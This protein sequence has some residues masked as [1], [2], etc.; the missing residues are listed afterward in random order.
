MQEQK[1][2][3]DPVKGIPPVRDY[4]SV[5][6][7]IRVCLDAL[8]Q[9]EKEAG[10]SELLASLRNYFD[11]AFV[12]LT[13][14]KEGQLT[15]VKE[16]HRDADEKVAQMVLKELTGPAAIPFLQKMDGFGDVIISDTET[17]REYRPDICDG[18]QK[19]QAESVISVPLRNKGQQVGMLSVVNPCVHREEAGLLTVLESPII[20][21]MELCSLKEKEQFIESHDTLTGLW[22]RDS[23]SEFCRSGEEMTYQSLGI[24]TTDVIHLSEINKKLGYVSGNRKLKE[25]AAFLKKMFPA[26]KIYRYDEDEMLVLC[27]DI[28][29]EE[30]EVLA[31]RVREKLEDLGFAV[32]MGYSWSMHPNLRSQIAESE[33]IMGNDKTKFLHGTT[34]M[35]R[36]EQRVI[37]E[38]NDLMERGKFLV[39][40]QPKVD[41]HTGRTEGAEALI[42]QVDDE[43]GIVGPGMFIPVLEHY[44]LVHMIDLFVLEETFRYQKQQMDEGHRVVPISV[45]FSKMTIIYPELVEKV[46]AMVKKYDIPVDLIHIEVTETVGDMDH[47]LLER[48][49]DCLK[50][51]GFRLSMDDFGS[52]YSNL[53]VLIQ[54]DFDS[55]KIDRSMVTEITKNKKSRILLDYMTS[56]I[57]DL[58]IHCIVEGIETKEQV[59]ILKET[60]AE[61]IQGFYFGKPVPMDKFYELFIL[62]DKK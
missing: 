12:V 58:G 47:A 16:C 13:F 15:Y 10:F 1:L 49:A 34:V 23:F 2:L 37:D 55:A 28:E 9:E 30:M 20:S 43:L 24:V 41:I 39:Y 53:A 19:V 35:Q 17:L 21:R 56:M 45:N 11:A 60:K 32:A 33:V 25:V 57:N 27:P 50:R 14:I 61:M 31:D 54:Y 59:D 52:H 46:T 62:N 51:L 26:Y 7:E 36:M 38:V 48:V 4:K 44:N 18:M 42:R 6:E 8:K 5:L 3:S 22:N 40:L 29:K